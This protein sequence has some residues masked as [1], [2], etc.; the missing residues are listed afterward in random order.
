MRID[1]TVE[2]KIKEIIKERGLQQKF[3]CQKINISCEQFSQCM[4]GKRK[5]KTVEF[6]AICSLLGLQLNDF[7]ECKVG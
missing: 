7:E 6:L 5:L 3:I 2:S 1:K 4:K